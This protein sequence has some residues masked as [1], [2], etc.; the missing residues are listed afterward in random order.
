MLMLLATNVE[1][2]ELYLEA[3]GGTNRVQID[4]HKIAGQG[5]GLNHRFWVEM[6]AKFNDTA[7]VDDFPF[8]YTCDASREVYSSVDALQRVHTPAKYQPGFLWRWGF[9]SPTF[10]SISVIPFLTPLCSPRSLQQVYRSTKTLTAT[11]MQVANMGFHFGTL[12]HRVRQ[13]YRRTNTSTWTLQAR[14]GILWRSCAC[15]TR[16]VRINITII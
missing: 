2:S 8:E 12:C 10:Q 13:F 9:V 7:I 16:C 11:S 15:I 6:V 5:P 3:C 1:L 4:G 14:G